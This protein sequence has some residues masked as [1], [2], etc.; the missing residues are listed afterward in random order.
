MRYLRH[1][2]KIDKVKCLLLIISLTLFSCRHKTN[3]YIYGEN[4]KYWDIVDTS[5]HREWC[6]S[7][8]K[9]GKCIYYYYV[10]TCKRDTMGDDDLQFEKTWLL[11]DD[12]TIRYRSRDRKILILNEDTLLT[13]Y[14]GFKV[15]LLKSECQGSN[16]ISK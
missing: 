10:G 14:N 11:K 2:K 13:E 3:S 1:R 15:L 7:F 6:Y 4:V 8:S 12:S 16:N 9:E 5:G